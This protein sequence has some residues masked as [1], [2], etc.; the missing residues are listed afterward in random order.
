MTL[1]LVIGIVIIVVLAVGFGAVTLVLARAVIYPRRARP[2]RILG[3]SGPFEVLLSSTPL[4]RFEGTIGLLYDNE[5]KLAVLKPGVRFEDGVEGVFRTVQS[6]SDLRSDAAARACGNVFEPGGVGTARP[7]SVDVRTDAGIQPAWL[8]PGVGSQA[9]TWVLHIHGMLAA[10]DSALRSVRAVDGSGVTSLV[11]SYRGDGEAADETSCPSALGQ[12]EWP[13]VDSAVGYALEHGAH[14]IFLVGWSLGATLALYEAERGNHRRAI[15]GMVLVS[16]VV[17]WARSIRFGMS[18]NRVPR[19]LTSSAIAALSSSWASR[20]L[21][22]KSPL[23]LSDQLLSPAAPALIIH[24]RGDRTAPFASSSALAAAS[25]H[26]ELEEFPSCPHAMEW[27]TDPDRFS[28]VVRNWMDT[29]Q[30]SP[31]IHAL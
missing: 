26:V 17:N 29:R 31:E 25:D 30:S 16:P 13:D 7:A 4:T 12:D 24:S 27:N 23:V 22:L 10:R 5:E 9:S 15:D 14:R 19:W 3:V 6:G 20:L 28:H 11:V 2:T 18:E 1:A 21:G 8:F